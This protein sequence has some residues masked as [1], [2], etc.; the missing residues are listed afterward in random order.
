MTYLHLKIFV[1]NLQYVHTGATLPPAGK[2][3]VRKQKA[4]KEKYDDSCKHYNKK[5]DDVIDWCSLLIKK[6]NVS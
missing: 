4:A 1:A 5:Y 6:L 3:P 2:M